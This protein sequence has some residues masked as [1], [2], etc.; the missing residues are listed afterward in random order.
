M[1]TVQEQLNTFAEDPSDKY[2][3]ERFGTQAGG[4]GDMEAMMQTAP[5]PGQSLT[6]DPASKAP[7]ETA[8]K[9]SD[10]Q[11]F[12]DESFL[13]I[14]NPEGLPKLFDSMRKGTP[15][16][17]IAQKYLEGELQKGNINTD[18]MMQA[19][20]PTIYILIHLATYG[21][22][23]AV[24]Y[25]EDDMLDEEE[26]GGNDQ[27]AMFKQASSR[28]V[29]EAERADGIQASDLQAPTAVPKSLLARSK[30]AVE[31]VRGDKNELTK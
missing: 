29:P 15:V 18:I 21:G 27:K 12:V 4:M 23:E 5:I 24:L 3:G 9:Y 2:E 11:A 14:S 31:A 7:Y 20:E 26:G 17:Y 1:S 10:L 8:P 16:E 25:P 13:T 22:V 19:I 30:K 28:I 6:Q